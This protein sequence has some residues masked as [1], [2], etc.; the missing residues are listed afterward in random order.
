MA[1][2][3]VFS[4]ALAITGIATVVSVAGY[5]FYFDYQRRNNT[6]FRK[7]L[8][9]KLRKQKKEEE[10]QKEEAKQTKLQDIREFLKSELAKNPIPTDPTQIQNVFSNNVELGEHLS[11]TPGNELEAAAKFYKALAVY[12]K[13]TD[14][15][16]IYQR[17]I[18]ENIYEIIVL[19]IAVMP[20]TNITD[21]ISGG[22]DG[23]DALGID[24]DEEE[25]LISEIIEEEEEDE[26]EGIINTED[27]ANA[28]VAEE[29][30]DAEIEIINDATE[31]TAEL[32]DRIIE[33]F[34]Q[35]IA[36]DAEEEEGEEGATN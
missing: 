23:A 33:E 22:L 34:A 1:N 19:M 6:D 4:S 16:G 31:E 27:N 26:D 5:A 7:S 21:F 10:N 35:E 13:P 11:M 25:P 36:A 24:E 8:K 20:P 2:S 29:N 28:P 30:M 12:P 3:N 9:K 14:L 15:L 32:A 18:P 17:T